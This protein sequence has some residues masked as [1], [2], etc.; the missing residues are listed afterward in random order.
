[1][2]NIAFIGMGAMGSRMAHNLIKAG[3]NIC[4]WNRS[5]NR[6][7][8]LNEAG[9]TIAKT[10][11]EAAESA[12]FV[13]SMLRDDDASKTAWCDE[14]NGALV[15]MKAGAIAIECSTLTVG[16][17]RELNQHCVDK[18][19]FFL[20]A[21]VAGS[22]P[23]AE[24][25]QL[26]FFVGGSEVIYEKALP[27]LE[28]M[29]NIVHYSGASGAGESVKL[30][31]NALFGIQLATIAE[32]IGL[33]KA[34]G[35]D[36]GHAVEILTSTPVCSPAVKVAASA[37]LAGDYSPMFPISLVEKDLSYVVAP[38]RGSELVMPMT[39]AAWHVFQHA[40]EK[41]LADDNITG[42]AQLYF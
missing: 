7:M 15:S 13:V 6:S 41:G 2:T 1:M 20:D 14:Q 25:A 24:A 5:V 40:I 35:L 4:V 33:I 32:L 17:V 29:G 8:P 3:H 27:V 22:R 23:Q 11:R 39:Q 37:M 10:P 18:D 9:A 21:P 34:N 12:D 19:V 16:W 28:D 26:I 30:A 36:T 38:I 42:I 31:V